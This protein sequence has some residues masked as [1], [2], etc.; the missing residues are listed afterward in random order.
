MI[1][2]YIQ[3]QPRDF[4]DITR[5]IKRIEIRRNDKDFQVGDCLYFREFEDGKSMGNFATTKVTYIIRHEDF[6]EA[7]KPGYCAMGFSV[8][9]FGCEV[10]E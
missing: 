9:T 1:T 5:G 6:P 3:T 7:L 8:V 4:I 10:R 2:E